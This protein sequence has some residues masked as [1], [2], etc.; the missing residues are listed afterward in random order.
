MLKLT[1]YDDENV[2]IAVSRANSVIGHKFRLTVV[3]NNNAN[4]TASLDLE[5]TE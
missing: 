3:N 4:E 1:I 5:V 2:A